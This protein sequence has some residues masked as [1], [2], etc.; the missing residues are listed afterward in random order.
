MNFASTDG[1][2]IDRITYLQ[3]QEKLYEQAKPYLI[4]HYLGKFIAF[5]NEV[6]DHDQDEQTLMERVYKTHGYRDILIK[7]VLHQDPQFF[8]RGFAPVAPR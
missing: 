2:D 7:Q 6:L 8:V 4:E 5:E 3:Q 1:I